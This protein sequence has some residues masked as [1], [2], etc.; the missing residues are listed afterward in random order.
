M[1]RPHHPWPAWLPVP[2]LPKV[3]QARG[4]PARAGWAPLSCAWEHRE[5]PAALFGRIRP[6]WRQP[7]LGPTDAY[8]S[9]PQYTARR[10]AAD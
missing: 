1:G 2:A 4:R 5:A 7:R 8:F 9:W 3:A 6:S 10:S